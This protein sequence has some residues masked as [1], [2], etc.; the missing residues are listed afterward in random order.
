MFFFLF[1]S[2]FCY[3]SVW[4]A[5]GGVMGCV[6]VVDSGIGGVFIFRSWRWSSCLVGGDVHDHMIMAS[7]RHFS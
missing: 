7:C 2:F 5:F 6:F 1:F 4:F 3:E